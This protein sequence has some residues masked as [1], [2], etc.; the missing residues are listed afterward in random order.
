MSRFAIFC[1]L[2]V[3]LILTACSTEK[4]LARQY[5]K[6][7]RGNGIMIVPQYNLLK[8]N[9]TIYYDTT[10]RYT[11]EQL[12]SIAWAQSAYIKNV[13]D[14]V[15]LTRYTSSLIKLFN[16]YGYDVYVDGG[17]DAFLSLP[18]PKWMLAIDQLQLIENYNN[19]SKD[20]FTA[21]GDVYSSIV[22]INEI[23]LSTWLTASRANS[24]T[25]QTLFLETYNQDRVNN[26]LTL[27]YDQLAMAAMRDSLDMNDVYTLAEQTGKKH[28]ELLFDYFM[29]DYI[30]INMPSS[31]GERQLYH[32]SFQKNSIRKGLKQRFEVVD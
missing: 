27:F 30:R 20:V 1:F 12:D 21:S 8:D 17:A 3:S 7:Y 22:R 9:Y 28:A 24:G 2:I 25:K 15:F 11:P 26:K 6:H 19:V 29:N 13:S 31:E 5:V 18:D 14:S 4:R 32:Y 10:L 23:S 16:K